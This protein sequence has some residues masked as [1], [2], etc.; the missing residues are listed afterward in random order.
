MNGSLRLKILMGT[1]CHAAL[2]LN[3]VSEATK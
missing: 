1:T 2:M 3:D